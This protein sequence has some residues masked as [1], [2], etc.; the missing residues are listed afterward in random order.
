M[1]EN[2]RIKSLFY[3]R[4]WPD[5]ILAEDSGLEIDALRGAPGVHSARFSHPKPT[6]EK[7]NSKVL[8]LL[9]GIPERNRRARFVCTLV[10]SKGG[11]IIKEIRGEVLGR[12]ASEPK[13]YKGF[14]Y[15]P[16]FYYPP[17]R[18]TFAELSAEKKNAVSHR[19]R[20]IGELK[21]FLESFLEKPS[22]LR[23]SPSPKK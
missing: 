18:K 23:A 7:N 10:L 12:I 9:Q 19:G 4:R 5:L 13:G 22:A 2:A 3:S 21:E 16:L 15:D 1:L 6:D 8:R 17:L 14:G 11:Q 20:A